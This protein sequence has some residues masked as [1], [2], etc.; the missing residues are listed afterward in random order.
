MALIDVSEQDFQ[1]HDR[2][3]S[4][5]VPGVVDFWAAWCGPCRQLGP[6]L[7]KAANKRDGKVVLAKIDTDENPRISEAFGIQGIPAV[8]AFQNG[9]VVAEFVGALP[10]AQVEQFFD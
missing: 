9:E 5:P 4:R 6:V 2:G 10:P 3:Q 8:K 1:Q 7:E